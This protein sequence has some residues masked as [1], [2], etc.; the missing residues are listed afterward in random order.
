MVGAVV[1]DAQGQIVGQGWHQGP[2][3]PHAEVIAL[4]QAGE[5]S[6]RDALRHLGALLAPRP[7][8]T[9]RRPGDAVRASAVSSPRWATPILWSTA[10]L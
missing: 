1:L 10:R 8:A 4:D 3:T 9:L 5:S 2:G 6:R 7:D